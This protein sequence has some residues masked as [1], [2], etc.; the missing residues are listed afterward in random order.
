MQ[1]GVFAAGDEASGLRDLRAGYGFT[2]EDDRLWALGCRAS[3]S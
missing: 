3:S 1:Q 2:D